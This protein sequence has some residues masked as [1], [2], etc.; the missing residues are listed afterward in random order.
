MKRTTLLIGVLAIAAIATATP[1]LAMRDPGAGGGM[2]MYNYGPTPPRIGQSGLNNQY[3]DGM[4]LYQY[5]RSNPIG[6]GDP[7]GLESTVPCPVSPCQVKQTSGP[8]GD[9]SF[10][11]GAKAVPGYSPRRRN[12]WRHSRTIRTRGPNGKNIKHK[13][14]HT[15][16]SCGERSYGFYPKDYKKGLWTGDRTSRIPGLYEGDRMLENPKP[17]DPLDGKN[18]SGHQIEPD[19]IWKTGVEATATRTFRDGRGVDTPCECAICEDIKACVDREARRWGGTGWTVSRHCQD[20]TISI[21]SKCCM[22]VER[23]PIMTHTRQEVKWWHGGGD[24]GRNYM[25]QK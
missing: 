6:A 24:G 2:A 22:S 15:W 10:G 17:A 25:E 5:V 9:G 12:I 3:V 19:W 1:A 4:N 23:P 20:F 7:S 8:D 18:S 21:L 13:V 11:Y 16:V 14:G